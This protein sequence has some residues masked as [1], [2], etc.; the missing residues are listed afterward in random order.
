MVVLVWWLV[1]KEGNNMTFHSAMQQ[2]VELASWI[3]E[4]VAL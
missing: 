1:W 2:A 4:E 3:R